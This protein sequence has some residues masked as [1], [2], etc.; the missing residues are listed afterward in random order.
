MAQSSEREFSWGLLAVFAASIAVT[1]LMLYWVLDKA[2][3][4]VPVAVQQPANHPVERPP[5]QAPPVDVAAMVDRLA[6]R[7]ENE[8]D[9]ASGWLM[10]ARS[11]AALGRFAE[12]A[13]A[14]RKVLKLMPEQADIHAD[15]ADVLAMAQAGSFAGEPE[16]NIQRALALDPGH[17]KALALAGTAAFNQGRFK[18]AL[19]FWR[20]ALAAQPADAEFTASIKRSIADAEQRLATAKR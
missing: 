18:E 15:F 6:A 3:N 17:V 12:A 16:K 11:Q 5:T 9:N 4:K 10:L 14:Y 20:K 2:M 19:S 7:L 1:S 8:P 13:A